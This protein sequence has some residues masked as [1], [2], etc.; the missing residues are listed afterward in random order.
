MQPLPCTALPPGQG[1]AP[2][3]EVVAKSLA[4]DLRHAPEVAL[5]D[6]VAA[7]KS[8]VHLTRAGQHVGRRAETESER[9]GGHWPEGTDGGVQEAAP[10]ASNLPPVLGA[11]THS[12]E[13]HLDPLHALLPCPHLADR[14]GVCAHH[15]PTLTLTDTRLHPCVCMLAGPSLH[16]SPGWVSSLSLPH[17]HKAQG[18]CEGGWGA[19]QTLGPSLPHEPG[20][21]HRLRH[22]QL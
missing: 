17:P 3:L 6:T 12:S 8:Q 19:V 10:D 14:W 15:T 5:P 11:G 9:A 18:C 7:V 4:S 22:L 20:A 13:E 2:G 1:L 21:T 16:S